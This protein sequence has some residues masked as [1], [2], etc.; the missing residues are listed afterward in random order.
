LLQKKY[1]TIDSRYST[2][3]VTLEDLTSNATEKLANFLFQISKKL[4]STDLP[5]NDFKLPMSRADLSSCLGITK[6]NLSRSFADL[7][8]IKTT[9]K[10]QKYYGSRKRK[11]G[12]NI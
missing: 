12:G 11:I 5:V 8:D 10:Q 2:V 7:S 1:P 4:S 3:Q 9:F 6:E